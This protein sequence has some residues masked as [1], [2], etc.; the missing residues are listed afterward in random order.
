[1][2]VQRKNYFLKD[3]IRFLFLHACVYYLGISC[4]VRLVWGEGCKAA[5]WGWARRGAPTYLS[6]GS[7]AT[8]VLLAPSNTLG[9]KRKDDF[10]KAVDFSLLQPSPLA[11]YF[12]ASSWVQLT[13]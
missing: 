4:C 5:V 3:R 8:Q 2:E 7:C 9:K 11:S 13:F 12:A 10:C 6:G 1:M